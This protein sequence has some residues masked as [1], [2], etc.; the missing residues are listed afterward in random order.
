L[1]TTSVALLG[2]IAGDLVTLTSAGATGSFASKDAGTGI[3]VSV[4]GLTLTGAQAADYALTQPSTTANITPATLTVTGVSANDK[5]YD[6]TIKATLNTGNA[7]LVGVFASDTVTLTL[8][9][10]T[11]TFA[12][13]DVAND[14]AVNLSGLALGG[15]QASNYTLTQ[16]STTA[17]ITPA[18]LTVIGL[19]ANDKAYDATTKATLNTGNATLTGAF[20]GDTVILNLASA[21]DAFASKDVGNDIIVNVS[22][23]T[24][25]G[26]QAGDYTLTQP[27]TTA[28]ITPATLTVTGLTANDKAYDSTTK[29]TLNTGSAALAGVFAGGTVTLNVVS[30]TGTFASK[31]VGSGIAVVVSGLALGGAQAGDYTLA[32]SSTTANITPAVLTVAGVTADDKVYDS[33]TKATL[34]TG[35]ATLVGVFAGDTVTLNA[36]GAAGIFAGKDVGNGITVTISGLALSGAQASNYTLT[37]PTATANITPATLTVTGVTAND[38]IYD[39]TKTAILNTATAA[40]AGVFAGDLVTL[41]NVAATGSFA[42][43]DAGTGIAVNVSGLAL[44]GA[45]AADYTL[46]QPST[47]AN[48]TPATL[49][50]T[51]ITAQDKVYDATTTASLNT[52]S[53]ALAGTVYPGDSVTLNVG[54]AAGAFASK[55]VGPGITVNVSGLTLGGAQAGNYTLTQPSATASIIPATLTVAGVTAK[56]K[57]YDSTPKTTLQTGGGAL[58]GVF[59][60]D[61]VTLDAAGAT[62]TFANKDVAN[63]ITVNVSGLALTGAQAGDYALT[64][65]AVLANITPAPLT[66][67]ATSNTKTFDATASATAIPKVTGLQGNDTVTGLSEAYN[68]PSP[69]SGKTLLVTGYTVNDGNNGYNYTVALVLNTTGVITDAPLSNHFVIS[70]PHTTTAGGPFIMTVTAQDASNATVTGYNGTVH[71]TSTD[72]QASLP[73]DISLTG[74]VGYFLATLK[75]VGSQA[76]AAADL[77]SAY[78]DGT[79][80]PIAVNAAS[81]NRFVVNTPA[82]GATTGDTFNVT[83]TALDAFGNVATGYS[84]LVHF[85]SSDARANLA[86]DAGLAGGQGVFSVVL[87]TAG[88]QT[89]TATDTSTT[90]PTIMGTSNF[91]ATRGLA[92]TSFTS[93]PTGFTASFNKPFLPA[94]LTLY[95]KGLQTVQDVTLVGAKAGPINGSLVIEPSNR[96]ITFTATAN[97]L[98]LLNDFSSVILPD[99]TYT[100]TLVSGTGSNGFMD[101]LGTGLDGAGNGGHTN[102]VTT[103]TTS[104]QADKA[105]VLSIPDFARGPDSAHAIKVPNDSGHGIPITLYNASGATDVVFTLSYNPSLLA[106]SGG[107]G[108]ANCDATDP[109]TSFALMGNPTILDASHATA[110]FHFSAVTA[111]SG[112]IVLGDIVGSVPDSAGGNYKGKELLQ[113]GNIVINGGAIKGAVAANGVHVNAYFGDLTGNGTI[114]GLDVATAFGVAQGKDTGL[115]AFQLLDPAVVGDVALDYS[116][117]A[118]AVSAIAAFV[119]H[120]LTPPIPTPPTGINITPVGA[121]PTLSLSGRLQAEGG[122]VSVSVMVDDPHPFGSTGMTEAVL[123]LTYDPATLAISANDISLGSI[124]SSG[125]GW[126]IAS[127]VDASSGHIAIELYST[128][129]ATASQPGSLVN[130]TFHVVPNVAALATSVELVDSILADSRE[131]TT[132]VD[133][134]QGQLVLSP[135]AHSLH[136]RTGS[137][138]QSAAEPIKIRSPAKSALEH[139]QVLS[140][141]RMPSASD[142]TSGPANVTESAL[143]TTVFYGTAPPPHS[144]NTVE[145]FAGVNGAL[146]VSAPPESEHTEQ[147]NKKRSE[148][149]PRGSVLQEKPSKR[150]L[151]AVFASLEGSR[152][153]ADW[154]ASVALK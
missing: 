33:S 32:Q 111:E 24:L 101:A 93:T 69:G 152:L 40:L 51:G 70:A 63:G 14:I 115:P 137:T 135:G 62:G 34:Q 142:Q 103:F 92:V 27:S 104:Y 126:Q 117:D 39:S 72:T 38:K 31:D 11:G 97:G 125:S 140:A 37:Q 44:A 53:A 114:D 16:P 112:N 102:Y 144:G 15:A 76:I 100:V 12:S 107:L 106:V 119:V 77:G 150:A 66:I 41:S 65:P 3:T 20:A 86:A 113:L 21:V 55:D 151:D 2:V 82:G 36:A 129:A 80:A 59:A 54:S 46:T 23:L 79:S 85:T 147:V 120:L 71:F 130:V 29:A 84:G 87:N 128:T 133:D 139:G 4:S 74:G 22:G 91:V 145:M 108:G 90:N 89:I 118:G 35:N 78:M 110:R 7:A 64:Q 26:A 153:P 94:D 8:V 50:V 148:G 68:N 122:V 116:V 9:G 83:V 5:A 48:I 49:T 96:T 138:P 73:A 146:I 123:A 99:D 143:I 18:T 56:D 57:V 109:T 52:A 154:D 134:A 61:E 105:P 127:V 67:T 131:F 42:S 17:N 58:L 25:S 141:G 88:N 6:S 149:T 60:G 132:Q 136:V 43:K 98:S 19:T 124:P 121:D 30:A 1:N 47:T 95:G 28:N 10:A 45:Q 13:K 81:A 75:T